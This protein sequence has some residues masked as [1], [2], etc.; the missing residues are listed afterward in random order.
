L[1]S[2]YVSASVGY[3]SIACH[4]DKTT[5]MD[6]KQRALKKI[7]SRTKKEYRTSMD[8]DIAVDDDQNITRSRTPTIAIPACFVL[9][10][11]GKVLNDSMLY[12]DAKKEYD[13]KTF[14]SAA[15]VRMIVFDKDTQSDHDD[16]KRARKAK[17]LAQARTLLP[18]RIVFKFIHIDVIVCMSFACHW[19]M[20]SHLVCD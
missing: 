3:V 19:M 5:V 14:T 13:M 10:R 1:P 12:Y 17:K 4:I 2:E 8:L 20:F 15:L 9:Q 18:S 6:I 7:F 11:G 16:A